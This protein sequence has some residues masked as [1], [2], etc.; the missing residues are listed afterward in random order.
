MNVMTIRDSKLKIFFIYKN[1]ERESCL[2]KRNLSLVEHVVLM[3]P[4]QA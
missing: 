2:K 3:Y 1:S 4:Y